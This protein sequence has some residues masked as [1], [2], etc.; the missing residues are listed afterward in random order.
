MAF[1]A[2]LSAVLLAILL[3][4]EA[5]AQTAEPA[6]AAVDPSTEQARAHFKTG[7]KLYRDGNYAGAL[8]EFEAAYALKPGPGSLQN[9]ALSQKALFRYGEAADSLTRLLLRHEA[10]LSSAEIAAAR[11]ARDE[12]KT[13]VGS[14]RLTVT[15]PDARVTLD[16]QSLGVA[17]RASSLRVNVGEHV[18]VAEAPGYARF[19]RAIR[20]A[21]GQ[22][23][24]PVTVALEPVLGFVDVRASDPSA[25][26][27]IDGKP[28]ALG[29]YLGPVAPVEDHLIQVYKAGFEPFETRVRVE[30]GQTLVVA[31]KLGK[32]DARATVAATAP[33]VLPPPPEP[34]PSTGWYG[35]VALNL[36]AT[37]VAPFQLN[38]EGARSRSGAF[39]LRG[40]HRLR[41]NVAVEGLAE[42]GSL[43]VDDA[44][45][46]DPP[47]P[48][49]PGGSMVAPESV[50]DLH[51]AISWAR[52]GPAVRIM[53][54]ADR[55]R[56]S[57]GVGAGIVWHQ[58]KMYPGQEPG[59]DPFV[60][61]EIGVASNWRQFIFGLDLFL[62]LDGTRG[63]D[64]NPRNGREAFAGRALSFIGLGVRA[65]FSEWGAPF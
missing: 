6:P 40:G 49:G 29:N 14:I 47:D 20:V 2:A 24:V 42:F 5:R 43:S 65:G 50:C 54:S 10:E 18:I 25:A 64:D 31:G 3:T 39:G 4:G 59:I 57:G 51:Y 55:L 56:V 22:E 46:Q 63:I 11:V 36:Q 44:C 28:V 32:K 12:L 26:I 45:D 9:I 48:D 19:S 35:L 7:T 60:L 21:G 52:L 17:E 15:P 27:A 23:N 53:S 58:L 62:L 16:G 41:A 34:K 61:L 30:V 33:G 1:R 37:G 8:A 38:L 13:L